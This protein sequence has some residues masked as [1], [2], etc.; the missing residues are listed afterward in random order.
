[1]N[2]QIVFHKKDSTDMA[3][4]W[5]YR[6]GGN[7]HG[8]VTSQEL[9]SLVRSGQ[10]VSDD[11]VRPS[12][13]SAWQQACQLKGL[14]DIEVTNS[15]SNTPGSETKKTASSKGVF[16]CGCLIF[17][18]ALGCL[19][20]NYYPNAQKIF[21]DLFAPQKLDK[22]Q[23]PVVV[24]N[25]SKTDE[26]RS[27]INTWSQKR[28]QLDDGVA[29]LQKARQEVVGLMQSVGKK[30]PSVRIYAEEIIE[31]DSQLKILS[32]KSLT[33]D[34]AITKAESTLRRIDRRTMLKDVGVSDDEL[35]ELA[36]TAHELDDS[37]KKMAGDEVT[38]DL[39]VGDVMKE[40]FSNPKKEIVDLP[41]MKGKGIINAKEIK[42]SEKKTPVKN[43]KN[44]VDKL[45]T[46][47]PLNCL[48]AEVEGDYKVIS[49]TGNEATLQI[50]ISVKPN[51]H[52]YDVY[53]KRLEI[54]LMK[55]AKS[56]GEFSTKIEIKKRVSGDYNYLYYGHDRQKFWKTKIPRLQKKDDKNIVIAVVTQTTTSM[57]RAEWK[58]FVLDKTAIRPFARQTSCVFTT[59]LSLLNS[60]NKIISVDRFPAT[61]GKYGDRFHASL[62]NPGRK[63]DRE[64][65]LLFDGYQGDPST[66]GFKE[67]FYKQLLSNKGDNWENLFLI[68]PYFIELEGGHGIQTRTELSF[69]R[70]I[71]LS[72]EE[73]NTVKKTNCELYFNGQIPTEINS[74]K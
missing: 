55:I 54:E 21:G 72:S 73:L 64:R 51:R 58:Y 44:P 65:A 71:D 2:T 49:K 24:K 32:M 61:L 14:F 17:I 45:L 36:L 1:M 29:K 26:F 6:K 41:S 11:Y 43:S 47:F 5:V 74:D 39:D 15:I 10:L 22:K 37:L 3:R 9:R 59:K 60:D 69:T 13:S 20:W 23:N 63:Y 62:I 70:N 40:V 56:S 67:K 38:L 48:K 16:G 68:S 46:E 8:P 50:K 7:E 53:V 52:S 28:Q 18:V 27:K 66:A 34:T 35:D 42:P 31:L 57:E 12:N 33:Y 25:V 19:S 4:R 30:S